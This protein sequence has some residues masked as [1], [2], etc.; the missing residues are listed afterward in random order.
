MKKTG[1]MTMSLRLLPTISNFLMEDLTKQPISPCA[2]C[3][4]DD[5]FI[6]WPHGSKKLSDFPD[7]LNVKYW[8]YSPEVGHQSEHPHWA[9]DSSL[10]QSP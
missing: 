7:H 2:G 8:E 9:M 6:F 10:S 1:S 5:T 4:M 3:Y